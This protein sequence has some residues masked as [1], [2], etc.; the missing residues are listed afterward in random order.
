MRTF[1]ELANELLACLNDGYTFNDCYPMLRALEAKRASELGSKAWPGVKTSLD[2]GDYV[3]ETVHP[4][5][6]DFRSARFNAAKPLTDA[7][8]V[9]LC[10]H[11]SQTIK[12]WLRE[13]ERQ[14]V[15]NVRAVV[16]SVEWFLNL[17]PLDHVH[18]CGLIPFY[19]RLVAIGSS[20]STER[21]GNELVPVISV[22][23]RL[24][25]PMLAGQQATLGLEIKKRF[26]EF[27]Q[28][29]LDWRDDC[30][31]LVE[32]WRWKNDCLSELPKNLYE[33]F[34][35]PP[36][37]ILDRLEKLRSDARGLLRI[38]GQCETT[39]AVE[40]SKNISVERLP[41]GDGLYI[42]EKALVW[43]GQRYERLTKKMIEILAVFV[44]QYKKGFPVVSLSLIRERTDYS[45][46]GSFLTQAFKQK[47]KGEPN[48]NPVVSVIESAGSGSYRLIDPAR[49]KI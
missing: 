41:P 28:S 2:D 34:G 39:P 1:C 6:D 20:P 26:N 47:R 49:H 18:N 40:R 31:E 23:D 7:E 4:L 5:L 24:C 45:F 25:E 3:L 19:G 27:E 22:I 42:E 46:D 29:L 8:N 44:G 43:G 12:A 11:L 15:A 17:S 14:R 21:I 36:A 37:P 38:V 33:I 10:D 13:W 9:E 48:E 30:A 16:E 35:D 32:R